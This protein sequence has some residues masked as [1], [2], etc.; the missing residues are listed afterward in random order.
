[1]IFIR[2]INY[3]DGSQ[4]NLFGFIM[5]LYSEAGRGRE[6]NKS[7]L[8]LLKRLAREGEMTANDINILMT[9]FL[10]FAGMLMTTFLWS[11]QTSSQSSEHAS[12]E[13][14]VSENLSSKS[15]TSESHSKAV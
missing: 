12:G 2:D 3:I 6:G 4:F 5:D 13:P 11:L 14:L 9:F 8:L 1:M 15:L 10:G 7:L